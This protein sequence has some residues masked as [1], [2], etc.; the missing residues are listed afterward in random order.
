[1]EIKTSILRHLPV[2]IYNNFQDDDD[3]Y[4]TDPTITSLY[5]DNNHFELY[6]QKLLKNLNKTPSL[7]IRWTGNLNDQPELTIEKKT[8]DYDTGESNDVRLNLKEKN[9]NDFIFANKQSAAAASSSPS[10]DI[11]GLTSRLSNN[12]EIEFLGNS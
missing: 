4:T 11:P 12:D 8:F 6:N 9:I 2:L 7:R 1:M 5:F 10:D 3:E